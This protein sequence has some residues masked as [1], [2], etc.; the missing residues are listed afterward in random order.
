A[1]PQCTQSTLII[2]RPVLVSLAFPRGGPI[3]DSLVVAFD[4]QN[5]QVA[6]EYTDSTG[7]A[8]FFLNEGTY[9]FG[10]TFGGTTFL[11]GECGVPGCTESA[12]IIQDPVTVHLA[13]PHGTPFADRL[14][15]ALDA[16]GDQVSWQTTDAAGIAT[17]YLLPGAH[18]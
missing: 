15:T 5:D 14:V 3:T 12:V 10:A 1:V 13:N 9:T 17:F 6:W 8:K 4:E 16:E 2:P 18:T 11:S 7:F